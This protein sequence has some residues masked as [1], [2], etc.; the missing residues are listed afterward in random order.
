MLYHI[1]INIPIPTRTRITPTT[2]K[3]QF[4]TIQPA[5]LAVESVIW[6]TFPKTIAT[7]TVTRATDQGPALGT[8]LGLYMQKYCGC[9]FSEENR[10]IKQIK[11]DKENI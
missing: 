6:N 2:R 10:Y 3:I 7:R 5:A 8:R 11:R 9:V 4:K 1:P